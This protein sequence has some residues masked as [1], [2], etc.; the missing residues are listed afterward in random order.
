MYIFCDYICLN[1][2]FFF[3]CEFLDVRYVSNKKSSYLL[4]QGPCYAT[5]GGDI[6]LP[7]CRRR[8]SFNPRYAW[9]IVIGWQDDG[10]SVDYF[11]LWGCFY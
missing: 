7:K 5:D 10:N 6:T 11:D 4:N 2:D 9:K 1:Q 3:V 8:P